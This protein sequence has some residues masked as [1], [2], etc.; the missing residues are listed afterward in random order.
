MTAAGYPV[1]NTIN[2]Q[3]TSADK[4]SVNSDAGQVQH[5]GGTLQWAHRFAR[6]GRYSVHLDASDNRGEGAKSHADTLFVV[7]VKDPVLK[8][9]IPDVIY[10]KETANI[11]VSVAGLEDM[12]QY[13][14]VAMLNGKEISRG[15]DVRAQVEAHGTRRMRPDCDV[16]RSAVS[17]D[18]SR[19][20]NLQHTG[21]RSSIPHCRGFQAAG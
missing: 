4:V 18:R 20:L 14:W 9:D 11:E 17:S 2:V 7:E 21:E 16:R 15:T 10:T 3:G 12:N 8:K 5:N 19:R 1:Q 6:A 13:S